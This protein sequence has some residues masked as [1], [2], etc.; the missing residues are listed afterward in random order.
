M[1]EAK[2][3]IEF[4]SVVDRYQSVAVQLRGD[5]INT[6]VNM[7]MGVLVCSP[8]KPPVNV[9]EP[10]INKVALQIYEAEETRLELAN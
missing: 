5:S 4:G 2:N 6:A 7:G 9:L 3:R 1:M 10:I 8:L